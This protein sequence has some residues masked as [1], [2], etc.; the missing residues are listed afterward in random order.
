MRI[1][2]GTPCLQL[3]AKS[4]QKLPLNPG[5]NLHQDTSKTHR[6]NSVGCLL[7]L[8]PPPGSSMK[9]IMKPIINPLEYAVMIF[10]FMGFITSEV[11]GNL[12]EG[13]ITGT[14][15]GI[16]GYCVARWNEEDGQEGIKSSRHRAESTFCK[17]QKH[18]VFLGSP[19]S[20]NTLHFCSYIQ[21]VI[22][23][24]KGR[25]ILVDSSQVLMV[26]GVSDA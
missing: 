17:L 5:R 6:A 25:C 13:I 14:G 18:P 20:V 15:L 24:C 1:K 12:L 11:N 4:L 22:R 19:F 7:R 10:L 2:S 3:P 23:R 9:P 8:N 16:V 21:C 26:L